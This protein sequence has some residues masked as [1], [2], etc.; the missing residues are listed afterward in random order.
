[1]P[2]SKNKF[3]EPVSYDHIIGD[4]ADGG[5]I[6]ELRIKPSSIL[7]KPKN[8]QQFFSV[9]LDDFS[10]WIEKYGKLVDK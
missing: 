1:M 5:K 10:K 2:A 8:K 6:G 7:W 9:P 3:L 4:A